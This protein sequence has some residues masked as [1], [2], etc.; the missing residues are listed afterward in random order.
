LWVLLL[1]SLGYLLGKTPVFRKSEDQ[2]MS[3]LML[4]PVV[5]LFFGLAG[6]LVMLCKKKYWCRG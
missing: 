6:S 5:L 3:C 2:R 1:T 4:L